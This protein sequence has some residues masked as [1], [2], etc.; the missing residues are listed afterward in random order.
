MWRCR[1]LQAAQIDPAVDHRPARYAD[2][3]AL[4]LNGKEVANLTLP[5]RS[6]IRNQ[7]IGFIFQSFN[8]IGDLSVAEKCRASLTYRTGMPAA[9]EK[10]ARAGVAG[11]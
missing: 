2:Q 4:Q 1:G 7:E 6:R 5:D 3:R 11:A 8:L 10:E 9:R